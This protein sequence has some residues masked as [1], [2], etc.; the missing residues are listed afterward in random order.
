MAATTPPLSIKWCSVQLRY[1]RAVAGYRFRDAVGRL[2]RV[3]L[4]VRPP[5]S[6]W[7]FVGQAGVSGNGSDFT[8][9]NP[10]APQGSQVAFLQNAGSFSQQVTLSAGTYDLSFSAAQRAMYQSSSQ[11]FQVRVD[12]VRVATFTP[13]G[14]SYA[15]YSTGAF[16]VEDGI[17]TITFVGLNP[18]GGD[19]TAFIDQVALSAVPLP[20]GSCRIQVSRRRRSAQGVLGL[21]VRPPSVAVVVCGASRRFREW[22]RL[23]VGQLCRP[24]RK[25][26]RFLA[27]RRQFQSA[28]DTECWN[29]QHQL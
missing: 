7:L 27:E 24:A 13:T 20:P 2:G 4:P 17:H 12:G 6:P 19:N 29:L 5:A 25:S 3:G 14:T 26:G 18:N 8:S 23:H 28:G 21:P 11:T 15:T 9:G 16:A 1:R 22:Q 10:V